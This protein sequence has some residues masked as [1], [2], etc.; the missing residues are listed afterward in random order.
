MYNIACQ[1]NFQVSSDWNWNWI[2]EWEWGNFLFGLAVFKLLVGSFSLVSW[3]LLF[4][5]RR[6]G[7][8]LIYHRHRPHSSQ[9]WLVLDKNFLLPAGH[10]PCPA[11][12]P[13]MPCPCHFLSFSQ[14]SC[15]CHVIIV[16]LNRDAL[17][18]Y[19]KHLEQERGGPK[20]FS[21][22]IYFILQYC[23]R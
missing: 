2:W 5:A 13:P 22:F 8:P 7:R 21:Q 23:A 18:L 19:H 16:P 12:C 4:S 10:L 9:L 3:A 14:I 11:A 6:L 17:K 1:V 15:Q 20:S